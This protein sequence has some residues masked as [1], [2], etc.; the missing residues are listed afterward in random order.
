MSSCDTHIVDCLKSKNINAEAFASSYHSNCGPAEAINYNTDNCF[1]SLHQ[2]KI[3]WWAVDFKKTVS[4]SSYEINASDAPGWITYWTLS[5]SYDNE[6]WRVVD[7]PEEG[8]P[9]EKS[10]PLKEP[11]NARF[12]RIDGGSTTFSDP[13][14]LIFYYVKFFGSLT[15]IG[16]K[17]RNFHSCGNGRQAKIYLISLMLMCLIS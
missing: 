9:A 5:V 10:F 17:N 11:V 7:S 2:K 3:Q 1:H 14:V 13:T 4:I 6:S 8:C 12:A 16:T 15:P